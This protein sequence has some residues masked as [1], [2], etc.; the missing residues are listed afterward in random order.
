[1]QL[2][3]ELQRQ[4]ILHY[5]F[6]VERVLNYLKALKTRRSEVLLL[7]C[8]FCFVLGEYYDL[9]ILNMSKCYYASRCKVTMFWTL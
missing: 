9:I 4:Q 2:K 5:A 7:F 1:M 8:F 3:N 6:S